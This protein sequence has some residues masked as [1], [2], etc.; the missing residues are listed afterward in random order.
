VRRAAI[1]LMVSGCAQSIDETPLAPNYLQLEGWLAVPEGGASAE[2]FLR[3]GYVA[4]DP[5]DVDEPR[6]YC[7]IWERLE[8]VAVEP[9][10]CASCAVRWDG[11]AS[12]EGDLTDCLDVDWSQRAFGLGFGPLDA[13][14]A[15]VA[16]LGETFTHAV[17][18][19]WAP[20]AGALSAWESL[21]AATPERWSGDDA[22]IGTSGDADVAGDYRLQSAYYWDVREADVP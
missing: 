13:G 20:D 16:A 15:A 12:V 4:D 17:W 10:D 6:L 2:G 14:G 22:P 9:G 19:D 7:E 8:L 1:A 18:G 11:L 5:K 21:Y 3:W